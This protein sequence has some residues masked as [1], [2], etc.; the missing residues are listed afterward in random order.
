MSPVSSTKYVSISSVCGLRISPSY[1]LHATCG[2]RRGM[3]LG[4]GSSREGAGFPMD[5]PVVSALRPPYNGSR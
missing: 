2:S 5:L 3:C 1:A 4:A